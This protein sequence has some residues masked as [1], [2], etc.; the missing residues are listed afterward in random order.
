MDSCS[1]LA[2][3]SDISAGWVKKAFLALT[4][5]LFFQEA[6]ANDNAL[7]QYDYQ[8]VLAQLLQIHTFRIEK[9]FS[10]YVSSCV[11]LLCQRPQ[12]HTRIYRNLQSH[13]KVEHVLQVSQVHQFHSHICNKRDSLIYEPFLYVPK[14]LYQ[15]QLSFHKSHNALLTSHVDFW[16]DCSDHFHQ[17]TCFHN[18]DNCVVC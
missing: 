8:E 9:L 5:H 7:L 4:A 6:W 14:L 11:R 1:S 10:L 16:Y 17:K 2:Y 3:M 12:Q 13:V 15:I 18:I